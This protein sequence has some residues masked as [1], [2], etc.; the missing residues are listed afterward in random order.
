MYIQRM[1]MK[2]IIEP[3]ETNSTLS[4]FSD[5]NKAK[6]NVGGEENETEMK[7]MI[8]REK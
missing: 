6:E 7:R 3:L 1:E 4:L 5:N 2:M 8:E